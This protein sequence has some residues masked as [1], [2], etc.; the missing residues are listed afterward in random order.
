MVQVRCLGCESG[1]AQ[2]CEGTSL[3]LI[4]LFTTIDL[5]DRNG[6]WPISFFHLVFFWLGTSLNS[7]VDWSV[8]LYLTSLWRNSLLK[9]KQKSKRLIVNIHSSLF[10]LLAIT[11]SLFFQFPTQILATLSYS[12]FLIHACIFN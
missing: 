6:K 4:R 3:G 8:H 7:H 9:I 2:L 1:P 12:F 5:C 10:W 11:V